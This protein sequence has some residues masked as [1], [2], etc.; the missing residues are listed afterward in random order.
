MK[1]YRTAIVGARRGLYHAACYE[2]IEN[3]KVAAL[4]E[5]DPALLGEG[6]K[7]LGVPGYLDYEQMLKEQK[8]DIVHAVTSPAIRRSV[9]LEAADRHGVRAVVVEKPLA[10]TPS[11]LAEF[12]ESAKKTN[13]KIIVNMQRRYMPFSAE[14]KRL[15]ASGKLGDVHFFRGNC[16]TIWGVIDIATHLMDCMLFLMDDSK[17]V[18]VWASAAGANDFNSP[19]ERGPD[20]LIAA[21]SFK[22]GARGFFEAVKKP[23]GTANFPVEDKE[24]LLPWQPERCNLDVWAT[25]GRFWWREY[26]TWGY[27]TEGM[28]EP[29]VEKTHFTADDTAAQREFTKAVADWLDDESKPHL[30]RYELAKVGTELIFGAY[31][32]ALYNKYIDLPANFDDA[33]LAQLRVKLS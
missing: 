13:L 17:P 19:T 25:K 8:P 2:G 27:Q 28:S 7:K 16:E 31:C 26:G 20:N 12:E 29:F 24:N 9:W 23:L 3:M 5:K 22:N 21:Y 15:A 14:F 11:E 10:L 4:C 1:V 30:N 33:Q 18:G 6:A 32:S